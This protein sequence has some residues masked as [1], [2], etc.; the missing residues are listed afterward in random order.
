MK[1]IFSK[2]II[3][4]L[5]AGFFLA[6]MSVAIQTN[7]KEGFSFQIQKNKASATWEQEDQDSDGILNGFDTDLD[8]DKKENS[9]DDDTD[10]DGIPN[11]TD[12]DDD[13]D[14]TPDG[15]DISP[16]GA[17]VAGGPG[18]TN[19]IGQ[20]PTE[21]APN[22]FDYDFKCINLTTSF[23]LTGCIA[24][25]LQIVWSYIAAPIMRLGG[26]F[27]DF[28]VY[29]STN[30]DSYTGAF[31]EQGWAV[32]RD[33]ANLFFIIALLYV[34]FKIILN[35][36]HSNAKR[37]VGMII[38]MA[39]LINFSLFATRVVIDASNILAKIFYNNINSVGANGQALPPGG[40][41]EKSISVGMV[42]TFNPQQVVTQEVYNTE[43]GVG[44]FILTALVLI[45]ICIYAAFIF[46]SVGLLFVARVVSLWISM[47]FSP[48]A[49]AS[50]AVSFDLGTLGWKRWSS[51]LI[52]NAMLAPLF[53]FFLYLIVLYLNIKDFISYDA[54]GT[55][56]QKIMH[57]IIPFMILAGLLTKAKSLAVEYAGELGKTVQGMGAAIGGLALVGAASGTAALGRK[58]IGRAV[59]SASKSDSAM[60]Y[61]TERAAYRNNLD[62]WK[63]DGKT[64][65]EPTWDKH[66]A[67]SKAKALAA[68]KTP[69]ERA[70]VESN[71]TFSMRD[72]IGGRVNA[73]QI[74][75]SKQ[76][77]AIHDYEALKKES[78]IAEG[79]SEENI[80]GTQQQT[81]KKN[82]DKKKRAELAEIVKS[83]G[84]N[85]TLD[86]IKGGEEAFKA[87]KRK[88]VK[89]E[90]LDDTTKD[91][92]TGKSNLDKAIES[93]DIEQI[94]SETERVDL[95][96]GKII[97]DEVI[98]NTITKQ[99]EER[100]KN[101]LNIKLS[102]AVKVATEDLSKTK[103]KDMQKTATET[104][105]G[106]RER[107][108]A[109]STTGSYDI[110]DLKPGTDKN[111]SLG[112]KAAIGIIA[113]VA[114]GIRMGM[115]S[116]TIKT[117]ES[118]G[119]ITKDLSET[120]TN[121]LK[122]FSINLPSGG[123]GDHGHDK[124]SGGAAGHGAD[125]HH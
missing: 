30:S 121:A 57:V 96:T 39:L 24:A 118:K 49:F 109:K 45:I 8:G 108:M 19:D 43:G 6:P 1:K 5:V 53:I 68:A 71:F 35:D 38:I 60:T 92:V 69:E 25:F 32:I 113:A 112:K 15:P 22:E 42:A 27:L 41:E 115:K 59:A 120:I 3:G 79:T 114:T 88:Q 95:A 9:V 4:T 98:K 82:F 94:K 52:K 2:I 18:G 10:G 83:G 111:A 78:G 34:A 46:F 47:V 26:A 77:H 84:E 20:D 73:S 7:N 37:M 74:R 23:S 44:I 58:Y 62:K 67:D 117:G 101:E 28:F 99:G 64:G 110:R 87:A 100:L 72:K 70:K 55:T 66:L 61:G 11:T 102:A 123:G 106:V 54:G 51:D 56:T 103:F 48:I 105:I 107:V 33:I 21:K 12:T 86:G 124:P 17:K 90:M 16:L 89:D 31:V 80:S 63:R 97:K 125:D 85:T 116:S 104:S 75:T 93:G 81:M 65:V 50:N 40:G 76:D 36:T 91:P 29:Y 119:D 13:G 14:G 122:G